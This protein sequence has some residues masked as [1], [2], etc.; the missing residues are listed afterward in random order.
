MK[1]INPTTLFRLSVLG[2]MVSWVRLDHCELKSESGVCPAY[3]DRDEKAENRGHFFANLRQIVNH[4]TRICEK[5]GPILR[6]R[7]QFILRGYGLW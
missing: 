5:Y 1:E 6:F 3:G 7:S 4:L 2:A